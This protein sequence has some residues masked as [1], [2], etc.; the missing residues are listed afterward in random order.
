[1][2]LQ[3]DPFFRAHA[4]LYYQREQGERFCLCQDDE[5]LPYS[6]VPKAMIGQSRD[7]NGTAPM[8]YCL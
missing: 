4:L 8:W 5:S 6:M 1:M 2:M 3:V 7:K